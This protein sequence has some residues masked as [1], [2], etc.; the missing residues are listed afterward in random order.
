[1]QRLSWKSVAFVA[2]AIAV[3]GVQF[4]CR[5]AAVRHEGRGRMYN[6]EASFS[7]IPPTGW[8]EAKHSGAAF[9]LFNQPAAEG[10][11]T[12]QVRL[13]NPGPVDFEKYAAKVRADQAQQ[14][15]DWKL[16]DESFPTIDGKKAYLIASRFAFANGANDLQM[17]SLM[18][19]IA[20]GTTGNY[21]V[22]F[23]A[24]EQDLAA[25]RDSMEKAANSIQID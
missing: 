19:F 13:V 11:A 17:A 4:S 6:R 14:F 22:A 3:T 8:Q 7:M 18:Y 1:M 9:F 24:K 2:V 15:K 16:L 20:G 5:K 21:V 25:V 10:G 12:V 23:S